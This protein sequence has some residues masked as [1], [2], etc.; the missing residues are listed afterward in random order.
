MNRMKMS[1]L[2]FACNRERESW[3][4]VVLACTASSN[5]K[6]TY[7]VKVCSP[8]HRTR[9]TEQVEVL[10]QNQLVEMTLAVLLRVAHNQDLLVPEVEGHKFS[11]NCSISIC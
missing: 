6:P 7:T 11:V 2:L 10:A 8:L 3:L 9:N 4:F 1:P 5:S